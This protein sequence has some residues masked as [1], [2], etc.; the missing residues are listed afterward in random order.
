MKTPSTNPFAQAIEFTHT[1][2]PEMLAIL[3]GA[4]IGVLLFII[5]VA[6]YFATVQG[7]PIVATYQGFGFAAP[8][9]AATAAPAMFIPPYPVGERSAL[10]SPDP[11]G[12]FRTIPD[13][14]ASAIETGPMSSVTMGLRP[15]PRA[16]DA[17]E[18]ALPASPPS[19]FTMPD[20]DASEG[21]TIVGLG[22]HSEELAEE[23]ALQA[24]WLPQA[25][26]HELAT[27]DS[28][29]VITVL[30]EEDLDDDADITPQIVQ[31]KRPKIRRISVGQA[32]YENHP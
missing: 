3:A 27:T 23:L 7:R 9:H 16:L 28:S 32:R 10:S 24:H 29:P 26:R 12:V 11:V 25:R 1:S 2:S 4:V 31:M 30:G 18:L 22:T 8:T 13:P 21:W 15:I 5:M 6:A 20:A 14:N 19:A 17:S